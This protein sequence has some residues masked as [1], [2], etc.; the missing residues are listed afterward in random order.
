M[1]RILDFEEGGNGSSEQE[2]R[3]TVVKVNIAN[4]DNNLDEIFIKTLKNV[5]KNVSVCDSKNIL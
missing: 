3:N 5:K 4:N 1:T 2:E